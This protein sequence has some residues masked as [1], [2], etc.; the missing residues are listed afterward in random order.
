MLIQIITWE[1]ERRNLIGLKAVHL[2]K[3]LIQSLLGVSFPL[4]AAP[5]NCIDLVYKNDA[6]GLSMDSHQMRIE[7]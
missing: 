7:C 6:R 4:L 1:G 5:S 2:H 3:Q